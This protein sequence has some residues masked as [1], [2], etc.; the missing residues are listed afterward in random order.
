MTPARRNER[1]VVWRLGLLVFVTCAGPLVAAAQ[2]PASAQPAPEPARQQPHVYLVGA[3]EAFR[4]RIRLTP[5]RPQTAGAAWFA[6]PQRLTAGFETVFQFQL[7]E[8]GGLGQGGDGFAFVMQSQGVNAIAGRGSAGGFALGDGWRDP[9]KPGI[10]RSLAVFFD[11]YRN[12]DADDP[13]DNYI[14]ICTNGP[15]PQMRW[16]PRRLGLGRKLKFRLKDGRVH[17]VR[18]HYAPPMMAVYLDEGEPEIRVPVDVSTVVD[19]FGFAYVGFTASTGS[20]Y[21]NHDILD[22]RFTPGK[23]PLVSSDTLAVQSD[24]QFLAADCQEGRNLCTPSQATVEEK[25]P[26]NYHVIL[27]ANLA[28]GASIPNPGAQPVAIANA[29]GIVC[30]A[31]A[32]GSAYECGGPDGIAPAGMEQRARAATLDPDHNRGALIAR[33]EKGRTWFSVNGP[34]GRDFKNNQGFFEF[35]ARL[36]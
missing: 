6:Q 27:P 25:G 19:P 35:D 9:S 21:Q 29:R 5:A 8:Q 30:W 1:L 24:I 31:G 2:E 15:I 14:A 13:S 10:P 18:I 4:G 3:A 16:P 7:T 11:T 26:G 22:W 20:G 34:K 12:G 28:W 17:T 32:A 36:N 23:T 33:T